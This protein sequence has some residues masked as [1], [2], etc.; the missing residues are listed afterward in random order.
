M[1]ARASSS[2]SNSSLASRRMLQAWR[3]LQCA[4]A[5][6]TGVPGQ[7]LDE[8]I[9]LVANVA[10]AGVGTPPW[11]KAYMTEGAAA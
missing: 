4:V 9:V 7:S 8:V 1:L 2:S 5:A 10:A 3:P 6:G 11:C